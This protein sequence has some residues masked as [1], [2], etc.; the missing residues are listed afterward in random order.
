[1]F[2]HA[3]GGGLCFPLKDIISFLLQEPLEGIVTM[4]TLSQEVPS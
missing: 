4:V 2:S 3:P 1:M